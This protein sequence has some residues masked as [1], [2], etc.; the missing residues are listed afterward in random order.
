MLKKPSLAERLSN[1]LIMVNDD[2]RNRVVVIDPTTDNTRLAVR[3]HRPGPVPPRACPVD[4]TARQPPGRRHRRPSHPQTAESPIVGRCCGPEGPPGRRRWRAVHAPGIGPRSRHV[5]HRSARGPTRVHVGQLELDPS[6]S[7]PDAAPSEHARTPAS[8]TATTGQATHSRSGLSTASTNEDPPTY[9]SHRYPM[10]PAEAQ[11]RT[12]RRI[13][14]KRRY[15]RPLM[16]AKSRTPPPGR[17]RAMK[18]PEED[19]R[20]PVPFERP[21]V[22]LTA[23]VSWKPSAAGCARTSGGRRGAAGAGQPAH[24]VAHRVHR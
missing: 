7:L 18:R 14:R 9:P 20:P 6:R 24:L 4:P 8:R 11:P 10:A 1:G 13:G 5:R 2:Y 16:P 19:R 22:Y 23:D 17:T 3:H 15:R 21:S 12:F